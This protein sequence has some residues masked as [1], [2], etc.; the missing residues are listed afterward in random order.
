MRPWITEKGAATPF[1]AV[2][3]NRPELLE[4]YRR[5]YRSVWEAGL[6]PPRLLEL[7]RL[8][9]AAIHGCPAEWDLR[10]AD[11]IL[12]ADELAALER[13]ETATFGPAE[14]AALAVAERIPYQHH[15]LTDDELQRVT[16][17]IGEAG[18][19]SLLNALVLFDA[20]CR[21]KLTFGID[22][23]GDTGAD[24]ALR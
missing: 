11:V 10:D 19:V 9:I 6:V 8:R 21:L 12:S 16:E 14:A 23:P 18:C 7:C 4:G 24:D 20:N 15:Q 22:T 1:E 13:G 17:A 3:A 5:F 2:L